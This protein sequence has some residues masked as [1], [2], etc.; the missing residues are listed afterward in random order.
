[1]LL[2][3][4]AADRELDLVGQRLAAAGIPVERLDAESAA[5]AGLVVDADRATVRIADRWIAPSVTWIRHFTARAMPEQQGAATRIFTGQSW[6][7]LADQLGAVSSSKLTGRGPGMLDQL[8]A[9]RRCGIAAP[10]TIV[11]ADL[12]RARELLNGP[13]VV[14]KAVHQHFVEASPGLLTGVFPQVTD[15]GSLSA[16]PGPGGPPV[17]VQDYVEHDQEIRAY[18][19]RGEITAFRISKDYPA[20]LWLEPELVSAGQIEPPPVI[21]EAVRALAGAMALEYGAFDFL[22]AQGIP[23]FLEVNVS[24][25]WRWLE[26]KTGTPAVTNAVSSMLAGLHREAAGVSRSPVNPISFLTG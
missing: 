9:A 20:Q 10:R 1:M 22:S 2:V 4:R 11:T 7:A 23:I 13:R 17:V 8:V 6:Q 19:T 16:S 5:D 21:K 24:G 26:T 18:F 15:L 3:S 14:I 25:D 12:A